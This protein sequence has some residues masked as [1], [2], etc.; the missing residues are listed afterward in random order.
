[1]PVYSVSQITRFVRELLD[2]DALLGDLW[3]SGEVSNA[4]HSA[5]GHWYFTLKDA[6]AAMRCVMFRNGSGGQF[7]ANSAAVIVHGRVSFYETRGD[8]QLY[9]DLVQPEG[10]GA[11]ALEFERLKA[12]LQAEGFF[13]PSRKRP[14]PKFP[15]RIAVITSPTGAVWHDIQNVVQRRYPLVELA[16]APCQVQGDG[17]AATIVEAFDVVDQ[18]AGFDLV[19]LARGG[20]SL[21]ELWPFN[22]EAVARAIFASRAP[23]VSG[24]GHETDITI[25][26]LVADVRAPTPSAAAELAVPSGRELLGQVLNLEQTLDGAWH[27]LMEEQAQQVRRL[28]ERLDRRIPDTASRRQRVD[29]HLQQALSRLR[30][31]LALQRERAHGLA[32]RLEALSPQ[33]VLARGYALVQ[34]TDTGAI[35]TRTAQVAGGDRICV[36][37]SDGAFPAEVKAGPC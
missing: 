6:N 25:A 5:A 22:E 35:V 3:V 14:L 9:V 15:K 4:S 10:V 32:Q 19:I 29:E 2:R 28:L 26:D 30:A 8:L 21:E 1:M 27:K 7:I 37:V 11:L 18:Q 16:L 12:R 17:A 24:V 31:L 20:G 34:R 13:E 23:V 33:G 36:S